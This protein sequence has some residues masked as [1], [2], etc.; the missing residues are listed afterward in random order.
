MLFLFTNW[1]WISHVETL[2]SLHFSFCCFVNCSSS[3]RPALS[4]PTSLQNSST[5]E[6]IE[7]T[8][9]PMQKISCTKSSPST[10]FKQSIRATR[11]Y[12]V[13]SSSGIHRTSLIITKLASPIWPTSSPEIKKLGRDLLLPLRMCLVVLLTLLGKSQESSVTF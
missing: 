7:S 9:M 5:M 12:L 4:L 3:P 6:W 1:N 10:C 2:S 13:C 8:R 11:S